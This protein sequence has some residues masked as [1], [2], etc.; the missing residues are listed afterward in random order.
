M[1]RTTEDRL[2]QVSSAAD[3]L[4]Q[5]QRELRLDIREV[6][7]DV[8]QLRRVQSEHTLALKE[9]TEQVRGVTVTQVEQ[10]VLLREILA[11][12]G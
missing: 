3:C 5:D 12:L 2:A 7:I 6:R 4:S 9:L 8:A 1:K 11:K 10:G